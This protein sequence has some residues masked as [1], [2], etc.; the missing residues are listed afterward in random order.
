[1]SGVVCIFKPVHRAV[2][3][4]CVLFLDLCFATVF[5]VAQMDLGYTSAYCEVT[6]VTLIL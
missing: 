4:P 6:C 1:M 2:R 3:P 5:H